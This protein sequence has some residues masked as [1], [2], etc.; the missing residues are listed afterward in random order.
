M[1]QFRDATRKTLNHRGHEVSRRRLVAD[2]SLMYL[3]GVGG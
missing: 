3:R 2:V 1:V